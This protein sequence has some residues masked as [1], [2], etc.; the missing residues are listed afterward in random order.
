MILA[1]MRPNL[2]IGLR[3]GGSGVYGPLLYVLEVEGQSIA[4][5]VSISIHVVSS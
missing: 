2:P 3:R 1:E 4:D 5:S